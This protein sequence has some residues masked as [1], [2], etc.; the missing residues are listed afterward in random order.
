VLALLWLWLIARPA[1]SG[2]RVQFN[3]AGQMEHTLKTPWRNGTKVTHGAPR[4]KRRR[5]GLELKDRHRPEA[6]QRLWQ[7]GQLQ[8]RRPFPLRRSQ[9]L[10]GCRDPHE[11][12]MNPV[13]RFVLAFDVRQRRLACMA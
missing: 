5:R 7:S 13:S 6:R 10:P 11:S 9:P 4:H 1:L 3:V 2:K 12:R 8:D